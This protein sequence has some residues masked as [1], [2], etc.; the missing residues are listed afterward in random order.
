MRSHSTKELIRTIWWRKSNFN[1]FHDSLHT[2][3]PFSVRETLT[4][5]RLNFKCRNDLAKLVDLLKFY[6]KKLRLNIDMLNTKWCRNW[7]KVHVYKKKRKNSKKIVKDTKKMKQNKVTKESVFLVF[8][9]FVGYK[10]NNFFDD[11]FQWYLL[12]LTFSILFDIMKI[13]YLD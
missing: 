3:S 6:L 4:G 12:V 5:Y 11:K 8:W 2:L 1:F 10:K 9:I 7:Y 13:Q